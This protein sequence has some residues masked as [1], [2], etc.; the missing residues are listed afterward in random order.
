M[1]LHI[2]SAA[3]ASQLAL[4]LVQRVAQPHDDPFGRDVIVVPSAGMR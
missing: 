4:E 1:T 2:V 3:T